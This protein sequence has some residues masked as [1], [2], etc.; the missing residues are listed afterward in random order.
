MA[1]LKDTL[2]QGSARVT[3]TLYT[4]NIAGGKIIQPI[5]W[6][7]DGLPEKGSN[8]EFFLAIDSFQNG[9]KT[10]WVSKANTLSAIGAATSGHNHDTTY[11]KLSG[12]KMTGRIYRE[13]VS[14]NWNKGRDNALVATSSING[15]SPVV[16]I[17]TTNGSWDIGA[18]NNA[19]YTDD[20]LF[21]YVT[22]TVYSGSSA[23]TTAQI[24]FLENGHIVATLDGNA[25][26]VSGTVAIEHGGTGA[27]TA[28]AAWSAL[29]GDASGKHADS[30]FVK[31]ITSTDNSIVRFDG[32]AGQIQGGGKITLSDE[33]YLRSY[34]T[35][36]WTLD[37]YIFHPGASKQVAE[38]YF[39]SG[40]ATNITGGT[41]YWRQF[42]P[43]STASNT[44]T[45]YHE[46]YNMPTV[47]K[48]LTANK[49]Y[50]IIT[51]K[52]LSSITSVGTIT[53]GTWNGSAI[54]VANGG[55]SATTPAAARSN[56][57]LGTIATYD[58]GF[59]SDTWGKVP[60]IGAS[61]GVM[62]V[63]KY[64]DFHTTD[65]STVDYDVRITASTSGLT[66][67]GTT[68]GTFSG[69]LSGT[70]TTAT[71]L[72]TATVGS[73]VRGIY[74][75][76]G[77]AT[78]LTWYPNY[79]SI[80]SGNK[81]NW[82][83][84]RIAT[85]DTGT[86]QYVDKD[87]ILFLR[88]CYLEGPYG[89]IKLSVRTNSS[90]AG[91]GIKAEWIIRSR[92][93]VDAIKIAKTG[94]STGTNT[95]VDVYLKCGTYVRSIGYLMEGSNNGWTLISSNE[96]N[97]TTTTDKLTS[98]EVYTDTNR[99]TYNSVVTA[100]DIGQVGTAHNLETYNT[101]GYITDQYGNFK[102]QRATTGD[103]WQWSNNAGSAK[104]M[105]TWESGDITTTGSITANGGFL[106][107]ATN[108][109][110]TVTYQH[111]GTGLTTLGSAGQVLKV[112]SSAN[113]LEWGTVS[114]A[115]EKVKVAAN[116][117]TAADYPVVFANSN[118]STT[119]A[120]TAGLNKSG[121]K[122]Y[123]NP[124][125][126][127]LT[128]T[129]V[130]NA[131][132]NDYAEYRKQ[133]Y[134]I[135]PGYVIKDTDS[136][137]I[138]KANE[139]LIPGAQIVSDTWGHSMGKTDECQTPVAVAGRVLAYTYRSREQYHAGMAVCSAPG[140]TIDIMTREEIRDYPDA[141]I[142]IVSEIPD[143]EEWGSGKVKVDGRIWIKVR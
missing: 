41:L 20:L 99:V 93:A 117:T 49:T 56:L 71:K 115:D 90:G 80:S 33:G 106:G 69:N 35:T 46:T 136:G 51:T 83:W 45:A 30:Y 9:G 101:A 21:S 12:G 104:L 95:T 28:S 87:C 38:L 29:G 81:T 76:S 55:T 16:S 89:I 139:R 124:S 44:P 129:Q 57:G 52:N 118:K 53:S 31:A 140:G 137:Y 105:Y 97:D 4:T 84:H 10:Y 3:D 25:S 98:T 96:V 36:R 17:K 79:C 15:Y 65:G 120:E 126:G 111:G 72:G 47:T 50:A 48:D 70:A 135:Q 107:N 103:T 110:G 73:S 11:L 39:D 108:V 22:D 74:L 42:S 13:G 67:S 131:I 109:T 116:I 68:T 123:F 121:T 119:A 132:W 60:V 24:K 27:T 8:A 100:V 40:D 6:T 7:A 32:T 128:A 138:V 58:A 75:N 2:I 82:P 141:I 23:V 92:Y 112:N 122:F 113:G 114:T 125:T 26:N 102:H 5:T 59:G 43:T 63:G 14:T 134:T 77:T 66:L 19:S 143:Y 88:A 94:N 130:A 78:A 61:D 62:E 64:I 1:Q 133:L 127:L 18:Y 86:G 54:T 85:L 37:W 91:I 34:N 142:G